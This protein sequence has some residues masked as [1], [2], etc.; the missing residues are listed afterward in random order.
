MKAVVNRLIELE[1]DCLRRSDVRGGRQQLYRAAWI[2]AN[3][4][5]ARSRLGIPRLA[6]AHSTLPH[7]TIRKSGAAGDS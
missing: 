6:F 5:Q 7:S 4:A 2:A 1:S 3:P